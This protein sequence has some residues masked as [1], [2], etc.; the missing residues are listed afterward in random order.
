M[1]AVF[2][3][4]GSQ[5]VRLPAAYRFDTDSVYIR[6]DENGDVVLS[7]RPGNWDAFIEAVQG[8]VPG[9]D[10]PDGFL[11]PQSRQ[12]GVARDL[13]EGISQGRVAL[14]PSSATRRGSVSSPGLVD[15]E[16]VVA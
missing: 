7:T 14:K 3:N 2:K 5:A 10:V 12:Q 4:D 9:V 13:F 15:R 8:L 16:G 1:A 6:R 11:S